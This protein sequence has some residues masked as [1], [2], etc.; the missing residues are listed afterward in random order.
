MDLKADVVAQP[1]KLSAILHLG[2]S[3]RLA[4]PLPVSLTVWD[5]S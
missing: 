2:V 4:T 1:D 5:R 3:S